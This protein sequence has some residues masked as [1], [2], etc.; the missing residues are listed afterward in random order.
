MHW[1]LSLTPGFLPVI[2]SKSRKWDW[3]L[4][5]HYLI[6]KW[7]QLQVWLW[8]LCKILL[9]GW[10][11]L[12]LWGYYK[13][14]HLL[15]RKRPVWLCALPMSNSARGNDI[16]LLLLP[17][18]TPHICGTASSWGSL[19]HFSQALVITEWPSRAS[20]YPQHPREVRHRAVWLRHTQDVINQ[21]QVNQAPARGIN[22]SSALAPVSPQPWTRGSSSF[23]HLKTLTRSLLCIEWICACWWSF[24]G[25]N[26]GFFQ[27]AGEWVTLPGRRDAR[28]VSPAHKWLTGTDPGPAQPG[29]LTTQIVLKE[30][31]LLIFYFLEGNCACGRARQWE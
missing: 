17:V 7:N 10:G 16:T 26:A 13:L 28:L 2:T 19:S 20:V 4:L 12:S 24:Q 15:I 21:G 22:Q 27:S 30:E 31:I 8:L 25:E 1:N 9:C 5:Y 3:R 29:Q 18:K 11:R 23:P 6:E 14:H